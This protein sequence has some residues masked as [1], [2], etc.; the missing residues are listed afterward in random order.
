MKD[1]APFVMDGVVLLPGNRF[2]VPVKMLQDTATSQSF[3]LEG[4]LSFS[5]ESAV[6]SDVPAC[7]C[8]KS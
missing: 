4:V 1:F 7:L 8:I 6:V 2:K 3:I 5:N